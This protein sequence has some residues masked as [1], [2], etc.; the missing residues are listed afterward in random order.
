MIDVSETLAVCI[1]RA[2]A[3]ANF[4]QNLHSATS[5]KA[6]IFTCQRESESRFFR[7]RLDKKKKREEAK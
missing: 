1:I 5:Q 2:I 6:A 7:S 3:L 4:H